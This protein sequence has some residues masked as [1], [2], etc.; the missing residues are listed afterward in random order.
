MLGERI[1]SQSEV[2]RAIVSGYSPCLWGPAP[3]SR[4][5]GSPPLTA[6]TPASQRPAD[7][8]GSA[9]CDWKGCSTGPWHGMARPLW[10]AVFEHCA[11]R[12][13]RFRRD[14]PV[15]LHLELPV[16]RGHLQKGKRSFYCPAFGGVVKHARLRHADPPFPLPPYTHTSDRQ[17]HQRPV[18][19][20]TC[21]V[22]GGSSAQ[23]TGA[24]RTAQVPVDS[25]RYCAVE[26]A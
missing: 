16:L 22:V 25:H 12:V 3:A 20:S 18:T 19:F 10:A 26:P 11:H 24:A 5:L 21:G 1:A 13:L 9:L 2:I 15:E 8:A 6:P 7:R 17:R 4:W 23:A 14:L